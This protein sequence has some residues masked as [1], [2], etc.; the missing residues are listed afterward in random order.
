MVQSETSGPSIFSNDSFLGENVIFTL[1]DYLLIHKMFSAVQLFDQ[2]SPKLLKQVHWVAS[3]LLVWFDVVHLFAFVDAEEF[4]NDRTKL[5]EYPIGLEPKI[6]S[7]RP[8]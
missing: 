8:I 2:N 3:L 4:Q 6:V 5:V 1:P 7:D